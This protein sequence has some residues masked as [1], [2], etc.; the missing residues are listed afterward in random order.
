MSFGI[1]QY[2]ISQFN[3]KGEPYLRFLCT[4]SLP[5]GVWLHRYK[6]LEPMSNKERFQLYRY[7]I[8]LLPEL[9]NPEKRQAAEI[10]YAIGNTIG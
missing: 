4:G 3:E 5:K 10:I 7:V 9:T 1:R 8:G 6:E 2:F